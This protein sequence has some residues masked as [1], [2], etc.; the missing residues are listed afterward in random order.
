MSVISVSRWQINHD[1]A[2]RIIRDSASSLKQQGAQA[3][4]LGRITTGEHAG[5]IVISVTYPNFETLGKA[6]QQQDQD[7]QYQQRLQEARKAGQLLSRNIIA[8][9]DIG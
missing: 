4:R 3:V 7:Q 8:V 2:Q 6:L 9:E 5:Q 1:D